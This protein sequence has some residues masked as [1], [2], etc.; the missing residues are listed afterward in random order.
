MNMKRYTAEEVYDMINQY[1]QMQV[2]L[3]METESVYGHVGGLTSKYDSLG[4][5]TSRSGVSDPTFK[6]AFQTDDIIPKR[7]AEEYKRKIQFIDERVSKV[8]KVREQSV[9]HWTLAGMQ[10]KHVAELT[11]VTDRHVRRIINDV[12]KKM[13]KMSEMSNVS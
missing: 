10:S 1:H 6:A 11:G 13:S 5:P 8:T 2:A 3:G 12:A 4:M 9:L 7:M